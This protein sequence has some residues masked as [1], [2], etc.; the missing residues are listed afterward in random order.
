MMPELAGLDLQCWCPI[1]SRW[2]HA[3]S[4]IRRANQLMEIRCEGL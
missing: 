1:T 3:D 2:R 4:L